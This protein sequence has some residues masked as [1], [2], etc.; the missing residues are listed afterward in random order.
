MST[1]LNPREKTAHLALPLRWS[2]LGQASRASVE[3]ACTYDVDSKGARLVSARAPRVGDLLTLERGR[4]KAICQVTW[5]ADPTSDLRGQFAVRCVDG[6]AP[7]DEELRQAEEHYQPL[8]TVALNRRHFGRMAHVDQTNRR[9]RPR[10]HVEGQAEVIEGVQHASGMVDQI[11][12]LGARIS[13]G[14]RLDPGTDFRLTLSLFD[15]TLALKAQVKNLVSNAGM[16]VEFQEIRRGDRP[17][18][19][20]VLSRLRRCR[21][22]EFVEVEVVSDGL[23]HAAA[24]L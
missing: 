5:V 13:A 1:D 24:A 11:S 10:F 18:L 16:G 3:T 12:E 15:V 8:E 14:E 9:R 7:W 6:R 21:I 17:L 4:N 2:L 23:V 19:G 22:E 20:Y